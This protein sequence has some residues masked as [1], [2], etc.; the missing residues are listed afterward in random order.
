MQTLRSDSLAQR[1]LLNLRLPRVIAGI[2]LGCSLAAAGT[3][4]QMIFSNPLVEPGF[5]GVSQ[6]AAFGAAL[7]IVVFRAAPLT[8]QLS[9]LL[10]AGCSDSGTTPQEHSEFEGYDAWNMVEYTNA[11]SA[12]LGARAYL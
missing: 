3:V 10:F 6:G 8:M 1:L 9:A 5:L 11:P 12:F 4:F 2:L 7:S